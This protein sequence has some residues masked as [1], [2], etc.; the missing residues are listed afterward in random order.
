MEGMEVEGNG[1]GALEKLAN[2][3]SSFLNECRSIQ[4]LYSMNNYILQNV[5]FIIALLFFYGNYRLDSL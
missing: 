4:V 2:K 5:P 1:I 3:L